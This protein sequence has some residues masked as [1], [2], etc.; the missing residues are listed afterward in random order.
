[1]RFEEHAAS[2]SS[3]QFNKKYNYKLI[4]TVHVRGPGQTSG[5]DS[6]R[7][8]LALIFFFVILRITYLHQGK[9]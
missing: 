7:D 5:P 1:M 2:C 9:K 8:G 6:Y 3:Y 4:M